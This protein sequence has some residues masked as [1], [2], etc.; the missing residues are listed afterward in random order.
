MADRRSRSSLPTLG[1]L[2]RGQ[3]ALV[4]RGMGSTRAIVESLLASVRT[5]QVVASL[6]IVIAPASVAAA[7][8]AMWT[9]IACWGLVWL[10]LM[11]FGFADSLSG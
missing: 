5:R 2:V 6:T 1:Q 7:P 3:V 9:V 11:L 10:A 8:A 4:D